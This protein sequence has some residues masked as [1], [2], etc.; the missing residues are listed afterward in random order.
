MK[1]YLSFM[2]MV[3]LMI[4]SMPISVQAEEPVQS[5]TEPAELQDLVQYANPL[6]GTNNFKGDSEYAGL[7]P[8]VTSPFG[9]TNFTPQTRQNGI[10]GESYLYSDKQFKGFF[11]THQP[12]IW[13]GDY[14]YVNVMPQIGDINPSESGRALTFDYKNNDSSKQENK[15]EVSTPYYYQA[16][17]GSN[18]GKPI[19]AEMTATERSAIYRY[20]FPANDKS[21]I[22]VESARNRANGSVTIDANNKEIYGWNNDNMS[23]HL[24][25]KPPKNLKGYF[26]VQF[27]KPFSV[28]GTYNNYVPT[29]DGSTVEGQKSGGYVTFN[30][31]ANEVIEVRIGTSFIS[32]DQARKNIEQE[33]GTKSFDTVKEEL[34]NTWNKKLN[35]IQ[36]E[37]AT[38]DEKY[39]FYTSMFHS[40]MYPRMFYENVGGTNK[41]YSP[42]DDQ[43]HDGKSYTDFSIWDTFRAQNSFL[44]LVAPE[45][46]DDMVQS[47]LQNYKEGGYMPKW[48]NP[49]YTNIMIGTHADSLVAEAVNKGF[50][51]FNLDLAYQAVYKDAMVPQ[52]GDGTIYKW[53]NRQENIPYAGREGL[54]A[55]KVLGYIPNG[56]VAENVSN[57]IEGAYDDWA[58]AQV[59]KAAGKME[60][61]KFFLNRSQNYKNIINPST[62]FAMGRDANGNWTTAGEGYAEANSKKNTWFAPHDPQGL[63]DLMTKYKGA[64]FYNTELLKAYGVGDAEW[65]E[66]QNEPTHHYAYM[67]DFSGRPDLTQKYARKTLVDSYFND[68][69]GM[70]G[71]DDC[72]QMSSWY[73]F[74]AMGFYPVNPAS[75]EYMIGSP[76]F[77]KV[78][79]NN[80]KTGTKFVITAPNNDGNNFYISSAKLNGSAHNIPVITYDQMT[81]GGTMDFVM[82][83]TATE[84]AKDYSKPALVYDET[85]QSP[86]YLMS[87]TPAD[88]TGVEIGTAKTAA[89]LG[90][91]GKVSLVTNIGNM[92][93]S[94]IWDLSGINYD[95]TIKTVQTFT[96]PGTVTLPSGVRNPNNVPLTTS[97]SVT[98]NKIPSSQMTATATSEEAGKDIAS[99][100][101]DGNPSTI[102]HTKWS[103]ADV[104]PQSIT[105][106]LGGTFKINSILYLPRQSGDNGIITSY[107]V[108]ASTD[109]VSFTKVANGNWAND[110]TQK[111]ATFASTNASY[112]KLEAT[113]G[114]NGWA[115]AAE[116][117]VTVESSMQLPPKNLTSITA[118]AQ[119]TVASGTAKTAAALGLPDKVSL[120]TDS[121]NV[122]SSVIWDLSSINYDPTIQTVQTFTV[123]GTVT[124]PT[125]V[126]N[127]NSVPLTTSISVSAKPAELVALWKFDEGS[128]TTVGDSSGK[129]NTG[130]LVNNPTWTDSGKISGALA[131]S[132]GSRAEIN[133]SATLNQTGD[134]S[135]SLWFKTSQTSTGYVN[136]FRQDKRFTALQLTGGGQARVAYWPNGS[137]S[138]QSLSF[139]WTY[140]DNKWHHYV[141][142]Y[143]HA[144]GLKVY[145]DGNLVASNA[146]NL[147]SLPIVTNKI[148]LGANESGGEAYNGLLDDVRVFNGMLSQDQVTQLMNAGQE[149]T[150]QSI[151][152]PA[153]ITGVASGT[154]KTV[155]A[156]GL[157]ATTELVTDTGS[158]N[159]EVTW[160]VDAS[161][162]DPSVRTQQTFTVSGT[163]TLPAGV[164]N[165]NNV[166]LTTSI[167]VTVLPAPATPES[168]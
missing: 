21:S 166:A 156:L 108:Y 55:Y 130:T 5:T 38:Q 37:G 96:V 41:Y 93:A 87:I 103:K 67:F 9:M 63:L 66:H 161:S 54:S 16:K 126:L 60:D 152:A 74:S 39:I 58:V 95:P 77:D 40:L 64:N 65:I 148:V 42:F 147:G 51:G 124:L 135:V 46:I 123:P 57:T 101:I 33:I 22:L 140:G 6:I 142:S 114:V 34:K 99:N 24:N 118:P 106:N 43:I 98:V 143:D 78:T 121:G 144:L 157:P 27:S 18:V 35:T 3:M 125:G 62:G 2:L 91:P 97:V 131:F 133:P 139:P 167:S 102:W 84:W 115:S 94:V 23:A 25:N 36:I 116:I 128:G 134:E 81:S 145:V 117:G 165:P 82:S 72:G 155:A 153:A 10:G 86:E 146:T 90:L 52:T 88:I 109:G 127:P 76:I 85:A 136:L 80:P 107:N 1:R 44:T 92:D 164:V 4:S 158:K 113:V 154:A 160:N 19:T 137:S 59:A 141:A 168:T 69:S 105:L 75:G 17:M 110:S 70:L 120:V 48:P 79:I 29:A 12:A 73:V 149:L 61:Y 162:Y 138:N 8:F 111:I 28:K 119:K 31:T 132:G 104:L 11:A 32:V 56:Y 163:V 83:S 100:A 53:E 151:T 30:T 14:G 20:T 47:L 15:E 68:T 129:G 89:A 71:N 150:L 49:N 7:S 122:D 112:V 45:R 159:A 13:M 26:V 50:R